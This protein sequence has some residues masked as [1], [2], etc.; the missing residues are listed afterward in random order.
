MYARSNALAA[1]SPSFLLVGL[2]DTLASNSLL[3]S[4]SLLKARVNSH[5]RESWGRLIL[6]GYYEPTRCQWYV[7]ACLGDVSE[8]LG[9]KDHS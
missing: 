1:S 8:E 5:G 2:D 7:F 9:G 4:S 6:N 3:N